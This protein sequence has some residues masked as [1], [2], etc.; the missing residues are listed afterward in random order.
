[1]KTFTKIGLAIASF[2]FLCSALQNVQFKD[3]KGNSYDLFQ[4][5]NSGKY[6]YFMGGYHG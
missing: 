1:M 4:L 3:L 2:I 5:L 6:V